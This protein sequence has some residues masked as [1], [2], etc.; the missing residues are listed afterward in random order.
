MW[1]GVRDFV[2]HARQPQPLEFSAQSYR[3]VVQGPFDSTGCFQRACHT[4]SGCVAVG[5]QGAR[6]IQLH[7]EMK[8][9]FLI[10]QTH[11]LVSCARAFALRVGAKSQSTAFQQLCAVLLAHGALL[12]S[13]VSRTTPRAEPGGTW[14]Q[15]GVGLLGLRMSGLLLPSVENQGTTIHVPSDSTPFECMFTP[16]M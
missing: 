2:P 5:L 6:A 11:R 7:P 4:A 1:L 16:C 15:R 13:S 10:V 12:P 8:E 14:R 3:A 9:H